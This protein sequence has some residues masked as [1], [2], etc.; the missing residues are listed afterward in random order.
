MPLTW[1][2]VQ[3]CGVRILKRSNLC[4]GAGLKRKKRR[5]AISQEMLFNTRSL[6]AICPTHAMQE[7]DRHPSNP[8]HTGYLNT[9][10]MAVKEITVNIAL[11]L[12]G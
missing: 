3:Q 5:G 6:W 12:S 11:S 8:T 2:T 7:G 1:K 10:Q 4:G 9:W